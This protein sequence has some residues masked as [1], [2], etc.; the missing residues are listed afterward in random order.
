MQLLLWF[1][2]Y[3][4]SRSLKT[5]MESGSYSC[6]MWGPPPAITLAQ[7][8]EAHFLPSYI[9]WSPS[10]IRSKLY[11]SPLISYYTKV[12]ISSFSSMVYYNS[13]VRHRPGL[14]LHRLI[15]ALLHR[16]YPNTKSQ[17]WQHRSHSLNYL[18]SASTESECKTRALD[19]TS[20]WMINLLLRLSPKNFYL[21]STWLQP[22]SNPGLWKPL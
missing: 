19:S 8:S 13:Y 6:L 7:N 10:K 15:P 9:R 5:G 2:V 1:T 21:C 16:L 11:F 4:S 3:S 20:V 12:S 17:A 22:A 14:P 18:E